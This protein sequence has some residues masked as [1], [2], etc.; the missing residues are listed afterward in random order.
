MSPQIVCLLK[1]KLERAVHTNG[2]LSGRGRCLPARPQGARRRGKRAHCCGF[3]GA[4]SEGSGVS[5]HRRA[6]APP[7]Q[8]S[9]L[10][11]PHQMRFNSVTSACV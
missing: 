10:N 11:G 3:T 4:T 5:G 1:L 2:P 7:G 9:S 6:P 8:L